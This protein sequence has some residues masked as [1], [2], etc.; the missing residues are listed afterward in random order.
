MTFL[1]KGDLVRHPSFGFQL[2]VLRVCGADVEC[3]EAYG[4]NE[5]VYRFQAHELTRVPRPMAAS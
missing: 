2:R 3:M 1:Q 5:Q 4:H